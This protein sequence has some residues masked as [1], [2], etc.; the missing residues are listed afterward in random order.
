MRPVTRRQIPEGPVRHCVDCGYDL[1]GTPA[2]TRC[3]ECG[4][5]LSSAQVPRALDPTD[6]AAAS[7]LDLVAASLF[8]SLPAITGLLLLGLVGRMLAIVAAAGIAFRVA[9]VWRFQTG[10]LASGVPR[11]FRRSLLIVTTLESAAALATLTFLIAV[12]PVG[13]P[14]VWWLSAVVAWSLSAAGSVTGIGWACG[15][16]GRDAGSRWAPIAGRITL[17]LGLGAGVAAGGL[18]GMLI[19]NLVGTVSI[20]GLGT[21]IL[22]AAMLLALGGGIVSVLIARVLL[23]SLESMVMST[24]IDDLQ[25]RRDPLREIGIP[26]HRPSSDGD[27]GAL[28]IEPATPLIRRD[29]R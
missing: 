7:G 18:A 4:T 23:L 11:W 21:V 10:P 12:P 2:A 3:P 26:M 20:D 27:D 1:R 19:Q 8:A 5:D 13:P 6:L 9:G 15:R 24:A 14:R 28:P 25:P 29:P 16:I 22:V 17:G